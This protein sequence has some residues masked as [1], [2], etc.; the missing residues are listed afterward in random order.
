MTLEHKMS[1]HKIYVKIQSTEAAL[2]LYGKWTEM[3]LLGYG[4]VQ[5]SR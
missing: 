5:Q 1:Y 2:S 4:A 3:T